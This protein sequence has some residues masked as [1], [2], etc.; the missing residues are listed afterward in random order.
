MKRVAEK[1]RQNVTLRKGDLVR[2][3]SGRDKEE[4]RHKS[5]RVLSVDPVRMRVTVEHAHMI[6]RH[7]RANP[8]KN[9][10]GGIVEREGPIHISNVMIVCPACN[11]PTRIAHKPRPEGGKPH[12]MRICRRCG[13]TLDK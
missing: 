1:I 8:S 10:K 3:M 4:F 12:S 5:A 6:K 9:I 2:V 13:A 11:K 7:T